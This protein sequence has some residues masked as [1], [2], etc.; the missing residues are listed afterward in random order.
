M[1]IPAEKYSVVRRKGDDGWLESLLDES[2]TVDDFMAIYVDS[3]LSSH[4]EAK[5]SKRTHRWKNK[6]TF[7]Y[8]R[9]TAAIDGIARR[10]KVHGSA[11]LNVAPFVLPFGSAQT[12]TFQFGKNKKSEAN[13]YKCRLPE[14][15]DYIRR[16]LRRGPAFQIPMFDASGEHVVTETILVPWVGDEDGLKNV[17]FGQATLTDDDYLD[18]YNL[19]E[20]KFDAASAMSV[21][22]NDAESKVVGEMPHASAPLPPINFDV[23][24]E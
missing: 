18:W 6:G 24:E 4:K 19:V 21:N 8:D 13:I 11:R 14:D 15:C 16:S 23:P 2:I 7:G 5:E 22:L 20:V 9:Y 10:A 12:Y 17:Y 1:S 3:L